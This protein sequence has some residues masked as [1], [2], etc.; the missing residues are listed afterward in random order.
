MEIDDFKH[1]KYLLQIVRIDHGKVTAFETVLYLAKAVND[2]AWMN[3]MTTSHAPADS[4]TKRTLDFKLA[5][6]EKNFPAL[7]APY[8]NLAKL[9]HAT[10]DFRD[11]VQYSEL[12]LGICMRNEPNEHVDISCKYLYD[13]WCSANRGGQ[14][15]A[16]DAFEEAIVAMRAHKRKLEAPNALY[17][18]NEPKFGSGNRHLSVWVYTTNA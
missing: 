14:K 17:R 7:G 18:T 13:G 9:K 6:L 10:G 3:A 12:C 15:E 11:S 16:E 2:E 8:G 4:M 5:I 1:S